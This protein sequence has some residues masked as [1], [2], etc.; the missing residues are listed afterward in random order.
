MVKEYR[1]SA[2]LRVAL[3][4][5]EDA[6]ADLDDFALEMSQSTHPWSYS[7]RLEKLRTLEILTRRA[8]RAAIGSADEQERRHG[9]EAVLER[10]KHMVD[11]EAHLNK[12]EDSYRH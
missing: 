6:R 9:I 11:I 8:L 10:I 4:N 1:A 2:L 5:Y 12:L 3:M 7:Q